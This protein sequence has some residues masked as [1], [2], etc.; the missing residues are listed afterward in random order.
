MQFRLYGD[1][2]HY[3]E[4]ED[5]NLNRSD[6]LGEVR[7]FV[8][9]MHD[10]VLNGGVLLQYA[11]LAPGDV[12]APLTAEEVTPVANARVWGELTKQFN[13]LYAS[14]GADFEP[15]QYGDNPESRFGDDLLIDVDGLDGFSWSAGGRLG[16]EVSPG[17]RV[18]GDVRYNQQRW[19]PEFENRFGRRFGLVG[20]SFEVT[21][22]IT[23][24]IGVGYFQA[25]VRG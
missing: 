19:D 4:P 5:E 6:V 9:I 21:R 22:L 8:D 16:Y 18:F 12:N 20:A 2:Y 23:G 25:V 15:Q 1:Y 3:F 17:Y 10:L 24:E 14:V 7:G 11:Q 13:R